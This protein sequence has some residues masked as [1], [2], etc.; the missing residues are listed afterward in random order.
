MTK[1]ISFSLFG[2]LET[3]CIGAIKNAKIAKKMF[4]DYECWFYVHKPSV[5]KSIC[6]QLKIMKHVKVI[7][8]E[9]DLKTCK[10]MM[11]RFEPICDPSVELIMSRDCDSRLIDRDVWCI[12][13]FI[14]SDKIF[15]IIRDHPYHIK[16]IMGGTF[17]AKQSE[18]FLNF[19]DLLNDFKQVGEREYDQVFLKNKLYPII[20]NNCL[21]HSNWHKF[22]GE[23]VSKIKIPYNKD[24]YFFIGA[25]YNFR[26]T[27]KT[28][29]RRLL[30]KYLRKKKKEK[31]N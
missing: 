26:S 10:P 2:A 11:W 24:N 4:P 16:E 21:I 22:E 31:L 7:L 12:N 27:I 1:V 18:I 14:K 25:S 28:L 9:G 8:K 13:E 20:K 19:K 30:I 17:A 15:N 23:S 6:K 29:E 3:Y 5:P